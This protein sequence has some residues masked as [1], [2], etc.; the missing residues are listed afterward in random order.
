[1]NLES[2]LSKGREHGASDVH[3]LAGLPAMLRIG[4]RITA[5]A[6][7]AITAEMVRSLIYE[8]L[9]DEQR[10]RLEREWLLCFS[11]VSSEHG[12]A[13]VAVYKRNGEFELSIRLG[14]RSMRT[15]E[16]LE[17]PEVVD[18]LARKRNGLVILTGPPRHTTYREG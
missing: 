16:E 15:R 9:T 18:E 5:A 8:R 13:R 10:S 7:P 6:G 12:R 11:A 14:D 4:G 2:L 17:L 1:M 3:V